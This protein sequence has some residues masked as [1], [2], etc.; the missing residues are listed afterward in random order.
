MHTDTLTLPPSIRL[1]LHP[2]SLSFQSCVHICPHC[3]HTCTR[4]QPS[5]SDTPSGETQMPCSALFSLFLSVAMF[6]G[7]RSLSDRQIYTFIYYTVSLSHDCL[8]LRHTPWQCFIKNTYIE[9]SLFV[10]FFLLLLLLCFWTPAFRNIQLVSKD[11][12]QR[13]KECKWA[14]ENMI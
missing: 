1:L 7:C 5:M 11:H 8:F 12:D 14:T 13:D 4:I 2:P 6:G 10:L 3:K 9:I